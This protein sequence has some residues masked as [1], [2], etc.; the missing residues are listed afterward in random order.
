MTV[1]GSGALLTTNDNPIAVGLGGTGVLNVLSGGT[2]RAGTTNDANIAA[3]SLGRAGSATVNIAGPGSLLDLAGYFY[4]GRAGDAT[5]N[6]TSSGS[7]VD[8]SISAGDFAGIGDGGS[9]NGVFSDGGTASLNI[10]TGGSA[11]FGADLIAGYNGNSGSISVSGGMLT[12]AS[13]LDLGG[14]SLASGGEGYLTVAGG[15]V[16]E[17]TGG[18]ITSAFE[19][20]AGVSAGTTGTI[21]VSG[22]GSIVNEGPNAARI[23]DYG[24]GSLTVTDGGTF[25][26]ASPD[27][28]VI[29]AFEVGMQMLVGPGSVTLIRVWLDDHRSLATRILGEGGNATLT[30]ERSGRSVHRWAGVQAGA[31]RAES[32]RDRR[33]QALDLQHS[34]LALAITPNFGGSGTGSRCSAVER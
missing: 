9:I 18:A 32:T 19:L 24:D 28:N 11:S 33:R 34:K 23:G 17:N 8:T 1:T 31:H 16:V 4:A 15:G 20:T 2:V 3:I 6:V 10:N 5:I 22:S 26:A 29:P 12:V 7:L 21:L 14:G 25:D 13:A 30:I 27:S